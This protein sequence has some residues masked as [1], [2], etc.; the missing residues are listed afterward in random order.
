MRILLCD[1]SAELRA[2]LRSAIEGGRNVGA[3]AEVVIVGEV[4][5]GD[6]ALRL[7]AEHQPDVVVMDLEMPGPAP[8]ALLRTL[9]RL[10]PQTAIVT[11]SG[12]DPAVVAG[13]AAREI[14]L[15]LPKTTD[16][17]A[18]GRAVRELGRRATRG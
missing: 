18:A 1:D 7:A 6:A 2:L 14:A 13:P 3:A 15:H 17:A 12:H 9:R 4:G 5:D 11:F 8:A 16:L 10:A